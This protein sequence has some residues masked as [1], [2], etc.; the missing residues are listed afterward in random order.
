[1]GTL[2]SFASSKDEIPITEQGD[3]INITDTSSPVTDLYET[4]PSDGFVD[5][6][7]TESTD[8]GVTPPIENESAR[9][10]SGDKETV[11]QSNI[12]NES[13][14]ESS[15]DKETVSQRN[16]VRSAK[17]YLNYMSF[18][19]EGLLKQL[20]YENYPYEDALYAVEH[21]GAD[22]Y[23]LSEQKCYRNPI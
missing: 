2:G 8:A 20:E 19:K 7:L 15:G 21:C 22:W 11:S 10:S 6:K 23:E 16:A 17:D 4:S 14:K 5:I 12:E 18:S 9:E 13:T 1:M 3:M